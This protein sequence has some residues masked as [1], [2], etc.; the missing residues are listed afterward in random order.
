[1]KLSRISDVRGR[2]VGNS[3]LLI[4]GIWHFL[5]ATPS[6]EKSVG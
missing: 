3:G 2:N 4:Y 5:V 1:M 6:Q